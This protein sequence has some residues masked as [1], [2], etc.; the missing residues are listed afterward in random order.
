MGAF[1]IGVR[2]ET[3]LDLASPRTHKEATG[4]DPAGSSRMATA[5]DKEEGTSKTGAVEYQSKTRP[6]RKYLKM[7]QVISVLPGKS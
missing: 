1:S 3:V 5:E 4:G 6:K 2:Y 7:Q